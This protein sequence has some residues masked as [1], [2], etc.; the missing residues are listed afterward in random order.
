MELILYNDSKLFVPKAAHEDLRKRLKF[1]LCYRGK[2][3][4]DHPVFFFCSSIGPRAK[5]LP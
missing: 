2:L 3:S 4:S 5:Y 1:N